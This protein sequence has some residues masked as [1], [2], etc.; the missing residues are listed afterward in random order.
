MKTTF[1]H[2]II[3]LILCIGSSSAQQY[4]LLKTA[5][6]SGGGS[7]S[8]SH[9]YTMGS[10][11]GQYS[12]SGSSSDY[13]QDAG[14][15]GSYEALTGFYNFSYAMDEGWNLIS[16]PKTVGN[17][18]K[19]SLFPA[20]SSSAF[21]YQSGY[22]AQDTLT[23]GK[24]YWLKFP[25]SQLVDLTGLPRVTDTI[26]VQQGWNLVGSV[27]N[28]VPAGSIVQIPPSIV[29]TQYFGYNGGYSTSSTIEPGQGYWVKV[30][31]AGKLVLNVPP[32]FL[33]FTQHSQTDEK[34][35]GLNALVITQKGSKVK[36]QQL[37]FG[38]ESPTSTSSE[39]Y[40]MPPVAPKGALD[41]RFASNQFAEFFS[42][43]KKEIPIRIQSNGGPL[44]LSWTMN[45]QSGLSYLLVE[46]QGEK[47]SAEYKLRIGEK[48]QLKDPQK[49]NYSLRVEEVPVSYA[50]EQNF[51]NPFNPVTVIRYQLPVT[52]RVTLKVYDNIGR[53]IAT[54]T[55]DVQEAGYRSMEWNASNI[56]SGVYYIR[57]TAGA[58]TE[59]K[60]MLLMK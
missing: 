46:K 35:E 32:A 37:L 21:A 58:F 23:N 26:N 50:L 12:G 49:Y 1:I 18:L 60:K 44:E 34:A 4:Y 15:W 43:R 14:F 53:L 7:Q 42:D 3:F 36:S 40:E 9:D 30:N 2:I 51:P 52:S 33:S 39:T 59:A 19:P 8:S 11:I 5:T 28:S 55:D 31:A 56:A 16:V 48:I 27:T 17:Y 13:A 38:K 45:E 41:I 47:V 22:L 6:G 54:L 20:S 10:T 25:S 29:T 57:M 24:G